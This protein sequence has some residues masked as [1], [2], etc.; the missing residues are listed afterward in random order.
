VLAEVDAS[1]LLEDRLADAAYA[2]LLDAAGGTPAPALERA[3]GLV[4]ELLEQLAPGTP[5]ALYTARTAERPGTGFQ[6]LGGALREDLEGVLD[7]VSARGGSRLPQLVERAAADCASLPDR[8]LR[9]LVISGGTPQQPEAAIARVAELADRQDASVFCLALG[10]NADRE[11]LGRLAEAGFGRCYQACGDDHLPGI[12][13][14]LLMAVQ[15]PV[16]RHPQ[17]RMAGTTEVC[18][19]RPSALTYGESLTLSARYH[20]GGSSLVRLTGTR[21]GQ[22]VDEI[23]GTVLEDVSTESPWVATVWASRRVEALRGSF[24]GRDLPED[25]RYFETRLCEQFALLGAHTAALALEPGM[26]GS[27][28]S[29]VGPGERVVESPLVQLAPPPR[30]GS[31]P[32]SPGSGGEEDNPFERAERMLLNATAGTGNPL[33]PPPARGVSAP[34]AHAPVLPPS[35]PP[36]TGGRPGRPPGGRR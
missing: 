26:E 1:A 27:M 29:M 35:P 5:V 19:A 6:P 8:P 33:A 15:R 28:P 25:A 31:G 18:L 2:I 22:A 30:S 9:W 16:L 20:E 12:A 13:T 23:H 21:G 24:Q 7:Q 3:K 10:E 14:A 4:T 17:L 34:A 32:E 11:L 36:Q